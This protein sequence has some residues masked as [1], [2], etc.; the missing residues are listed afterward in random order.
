MSFWCSVRG[1]WLTLGILTQAASD[2]LTGA[3]FHFYVFSTLGNA[4]MHSRSGAFHE[5]AKLFALKNRKALAIPREAVLTILPVFIALSH[6]KTLPIQQTEI[7]EQGRCNPHPKDAKASFAT[8][9]DSSNP[10]CSRSPMARKTHFLASSL[11]PLVRWR[12]P[13]LR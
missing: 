7:L 3:K 11:L 6:F 2:G 8:F 4:I 1:S 13:R 12:S 9:R 5:S 10:H